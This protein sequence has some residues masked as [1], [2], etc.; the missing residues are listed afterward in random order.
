MDAEGSAL[1]HESIEQQRRLLSNAVVFD[2]EQLEFVNNQE[3]ARHDCLAVRQ[4][5]VTYVLNARGAKALA[6]LFQFSVQPLQHA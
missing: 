1:A 4:P 6:A 3:N 2:E 5:K